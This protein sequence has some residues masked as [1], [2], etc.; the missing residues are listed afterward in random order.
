MGKY[1]DLS[2]NR[3]GRLVVLKR[4][5]TTKNGGV[6]WLLMIW[7]QEVRN[8]MTC[9]EKIDEIEKILDDEYETK[10]ERIREVV[11]DAEDK[12]IP[13]DKIK[14]AREEISKQFV[15]LQDGS[16]EWRSYVNETVFECVEIMD[17]LIES[18]W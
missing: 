5:D 10:I 12:E 14:K 6:R 11:D 15:D 16:E 1:V 2:G 4:Y 17:K 8:R 13:T 3:Y 7:F 9:K 18:E